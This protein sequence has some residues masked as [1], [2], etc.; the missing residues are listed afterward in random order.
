MNYQIC[1]F[2]GH[3]KINIEKGIVKK[4]YT[5]IEGLIVKNNVKVFLFGSNSDFNSLAYDVVTKLKIK[6]PNI[7]RIYVRAEYQ[8]TNKEYREYLNQKY[9]FSYYPKKIIGVGK[10]VYVKRN[11]LIIKNSDICI[12]YFNGINSKKS[13]CKTLNSGTCLAYLYAKKQNKNI[14]NIFNFLNS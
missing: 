1:S 9:E 6:Y 8:A 5:V 3:R 10:L 12:F 2:I 14:I 11:E 13:G 4:L 7:K